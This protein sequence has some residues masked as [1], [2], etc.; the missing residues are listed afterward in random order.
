[1]GATLSEAKSWGK[2][3]A[4]AKAVTVYV[5]ATIALPVLVAAV[6]SRFG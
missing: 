4:D 6:R 1:S 2:V 5:D 3:N